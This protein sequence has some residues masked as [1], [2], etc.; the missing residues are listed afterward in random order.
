MSKAA[1]T[2]NGAFAGLSDMLSGGFDAGLTSEGAQRQMFRLDD[3]E[4]ESQVREEFEDDE[5]SLNDL[6]ESLMKEQIQPILLRKNRPGRIKPYLLVAG[7]RRYMAA[8]LKMILELWGDYRP[9]M[10]DEDAERIQFAENIQRKN[11]TQIEEAKRIQRDLDTLGS[12]DAVLAKHNKS[13]PWLSKT[14]ALLHLPEQAKRLVKENISADLEVINTV[15]TIEKADPAKARELVDDL[16]QTRGKANARDKAA[17]AKEEVKPSK[18]AKKDP[19]GSVA[20]ARDRK[21]EEPG[22]GDVFAPAKSARSTRP[23]HEDVLARAYD[24]IFEGGNSPKAVLEGISNTERDAVDT[25]LSTFYEAGK[26]GDNIGRAVI[27]GF[28]NGGFSGDGVGGFAL[29]AYLQGA[30]G[31]AQFSSLNIFGCMKP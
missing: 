29:V 30:D 2:N 7:G 1:T 13:R 22:K 28:R 8:E 18:K 10:T 16:K 31:K 21:H 19:G 4:V 26:Q 25:F 9:E 17:Q 24:S 11:L 3:I 14:M 5:N 6:G 20:A 12:V 23:V 15:K 27:E